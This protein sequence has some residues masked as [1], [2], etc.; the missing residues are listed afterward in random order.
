MAATT[1]Q[2]IK[3]LIA[4]LKQDYPDIRFKKGDDCSW[5]HTTGRITYIDNDDCCP[6]LL[7][8]LAHAQLGH[9]NY[10]LDIELIVQES[11][12]WDKAMCE[13]SLTY[14]VPIGPQLIQDALDTYRE[15]LYAR[16]TCPKCQQTGIQNQTSAY[17]C[18][19]CRCSWHPND[20]RKCALR[21]SVLI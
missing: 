3:K 2:P 18:I 9:T 19:N 1:T 11:L 7:H 15:W 17:V 13:F 20:A 21:R 6:Y 16:S 5:S 12:A 8:E 10:K 14:S 4:R